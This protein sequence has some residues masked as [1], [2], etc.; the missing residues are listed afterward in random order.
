[1]ETRRK[2]LQASATAAVFSRSVLGAN[3]RVQM[4]IIGTGNRGGQVFQGFS[5]HKDQVFVAACDVARDRLDSFVSKAPNKMTTFTDYRKVLERKDIDA[6][7]ITTP[8][9]WHAPIMIAAIQAGKDVYVEKPISNKIEPAQQMVD[10]VHKSDRI[11]QVGLQQRSWD[12]FAEAVKLVHDGYIGNVTHASTIYS[13]YMPVPVMDPTTPVPDTLDWEMYQGPVAHRAYSPMRQ[14]RWRAYYDY[15]GGMITDWG[16][17]LV[18]IAHWGMKADS[19]VAKMTS[20]SAGYIGVANP[21]LDQTPNAFAITW[22]YD[23]FIMTFMNAEIPNP[24]EPDFPLW[25]TYWYGSKGVLMVNRLGYKVWPKTAFPSAPTPAQTNRGQAT[26]PQSV[27]A[28]PPIEAKSYKNPLAWGADATPLHV[29]NFLDCV[30]SRKQPVA[31][32]DIG[33]HSSLPCI[34]ALLSIRNKRQYAW[35]AAAKTA[36]PA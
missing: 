14:R 5:Q 11:V 15:G 8:D 31:T 7:L 21:D 34:I 30:K 20:S 25:G 10:A 17:H 35:D 13:N 6:V 29:R 16:V 36:K 22:E 27:P 4:A 1:M 23:D 2:F 18:D 9:H 28:G 3:D 33:F 19:K 26:L 24:A 32:I 12:H